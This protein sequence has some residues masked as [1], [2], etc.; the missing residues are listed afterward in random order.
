MD[1]AIYAWG[2]RNARQKE[3][4]IRLYILCMEAFVAVDSGGESTPHPAAVGYIKKNIRE[5]T[6]SY[7]ADAIFTL[8]PIQQTK[9][10][11]FRPF[12]LTKV[13]SPE[14]IFQNISSSI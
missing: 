4:E 12:N 6:I 9:S 7:A 5:Q 1:K 14:A 2:D 11:R 10:L 13:R 8:F 3:K